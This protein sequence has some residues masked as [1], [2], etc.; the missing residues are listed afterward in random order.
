MEQEYSTTTSLQNIKYSRYKY[1]IFSEK[2]LNCD[3]KRIAAVVFVYS[4]NVKF[5][6]KPDI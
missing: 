6:T 2:T 1:C 5:K 4:V 3:D